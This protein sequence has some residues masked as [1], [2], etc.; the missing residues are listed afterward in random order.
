MT[1]FIDLPVLVATKDGRNFI[2]TDNAHYISQDG[3]QYRIPTGAMTDRASTPPIIWEKFNLEWLPPFGSYW[4]AAVLHDC[5]YRNVLL[6]K[7][8]NNNWI[9]ARLTKDF[10]DN[11]FKEAMISLG[12][13]QRTVDEI[14]EGVVTFGQ[15]SF[16]EDRKAN[17]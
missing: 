3:T 9:T 17:P 14:Y 4:P 10:C 8:S 12:T 2:L 13:H 1:G 16:D 15:H 7:D 6:V 5:A 11:L